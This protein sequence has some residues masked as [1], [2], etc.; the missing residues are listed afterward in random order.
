VTD[1]SVG[2]RLF[3]HRAFRIMRLDD[4]YKMTAFIYQDANAIRSKEA[5]Y[6][7]FVEVG[8]MLTQLDRKKKRV[9]VDVDSAI[10]KALRWYFPL[11][12]KMGIS[13]VE[14]LVFIKYPGVCPYCREKPHNDGRCKLVRGADA[15]V[16]HEEVLRLVEQNRTSMPADLKWRRMFSEISALA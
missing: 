16:S 5:T 8:G 12:A 3:M 7:H 15:T 6:L 11:L 9:K 4:L 2:L 1:G 13:S 10:C 14:E